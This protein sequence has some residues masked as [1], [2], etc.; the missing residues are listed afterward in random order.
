MGRR[1]AEGTLSCRGTHICRGE[2]D[3]IGQMWEACL[4]SGAMAM[5]GPEL[6][7]GSTS[8]SWPH[9]SC[10]LCLYPWILLT[11]EGCEEA[12]GLAATCGLIGA[13]DLCHSR[14]YP[15]LSGLGCH[16]EPQRDPGP[17]CSWGPCLGSV[18]L[19]HPGSVLMFMVPG[20]IEGLADA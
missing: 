10:R 6:L 8:R 11:T 12:W 14:G 19:S 5:L 20:T 4:P 15:D 2:G 17:C 3:V 9:C 13:R 7:P 1:E 18:S 16:P